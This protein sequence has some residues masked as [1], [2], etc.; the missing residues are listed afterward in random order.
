[1]LGTV[2]GKAV[3][4]LTASILICSSFSSY[5]CDMEG[6]A[7]MVLEKNV[8]DSFVFTGLTEQQKLMVKNLIF[9]TPNVAFIPK[10]TFT[11]FPNLNR[12]CIHGTDFDYLSV[13]YF[14]FFPE[15]HTIT[16]FD[17]HRSKIDKIDP[18]VWQYIKNGNIF[19]FQ[20]NVCLNE[21]FTDPQIL[22]K[23]IQKCYRNFRQSNH[24]TN[25][26]IKE[27]IEQQKQL[28]IYLDD[29]INGNSA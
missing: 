23:K 25:K 8:S 10:E 24:Y 27:N 2:L 4:I 1:M 9:R 13:D 11:T 22:L 12:I 26:L 16:G 18:D 5:T 28:K 6:N 21:N 17:F 7:G 20:R 19:F 3:P 29:I 14:R 15:N